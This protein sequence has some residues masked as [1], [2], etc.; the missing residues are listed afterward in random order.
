VDV[1]A[2][3]LG[4]QELKAVV[5]TTDSTK[6][7]RIGAFTAYN[8]RAPF[9][10]VIELPGTLQA[11]N[12]DSGA[13]GISYH[14]TDTKNE[15]G[16]SYRNNGGGVDI[17]IGNS[18]YVIGYT[19]A[20]EWLEYTVEVLKDAEFG[21]E[22]SASNGSSSFEFDVL[23]DGQKLTTLSGEKTAD[24]DTYAVVKSKSKVSLTKGKHVIKV[25]FNTN[26][27]N[28]DYIEFTGE[29][30]DPADVD[31]VMLE[32]K[33]VEIYPNPARNEFVVE[34]QSA[35]RSVKVMTMSGVEVKT[36]EN[37]T[38]DVS[39]LSSGCYFVEVTTE[40]A[41]VVKKVMVVR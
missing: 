28:L 34:A 33:S 27:T 20:G 2:T 19:N 41:V 40:E 3:S 26:Y 15:G 35:I 32:A 10:G 14:D 8:P 30:V 21:I 1:V 24:W 7:E 39:N 23:S 37:K 31:D 5:V 11:E 22:A 38:V 16:T 17:V 25:V 4:R 18:G 13:E 29:K 6:Y 9:K 12:F 36:S